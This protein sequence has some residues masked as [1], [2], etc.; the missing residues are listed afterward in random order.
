MNKLKLILKILFDKELL[1]L[2]REEK[3]LNC[4]K[5]KYMAD[6]TSVNMLASALKNIIIEK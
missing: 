4:Y 5:S 3:V 6:N 2:E 1:I